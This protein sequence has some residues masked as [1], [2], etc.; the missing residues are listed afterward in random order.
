MRCYFH[1]VNGRETVSYDRDIEVSNLETVQCLALRA[2]YQIRDEANKVNEDWQG[3]RLDVV[4]PSGGI[5]M[6][7]PLDTML[8]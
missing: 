1:L 5:L 8:Q 4:D 6:S 3:W 7:I 2:I